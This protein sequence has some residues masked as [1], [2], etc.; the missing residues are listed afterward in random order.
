MCRRVQCFVSLTAINIDT[1]MNGYKTEQVTI[2]NG[3]IFIN[4]FNIKYEEF[5]SQYYLDCPP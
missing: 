2:E 3:A 1:K 5:S 4:V